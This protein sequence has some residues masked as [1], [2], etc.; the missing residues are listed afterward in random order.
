MATKGIRL[1]DP[2][3]PYVSSAATDLRKTFARIRKEQKQ[4]TLKE[5]QQERQN[6]Q[7][8]CVCEHCYHGCQN[9]N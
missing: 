7:D 3:F 8:S 2:N 5:I 6:M 4:Q 1:L 9:D